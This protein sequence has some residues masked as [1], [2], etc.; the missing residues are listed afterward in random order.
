[1]R[2]DLTSITNAKLLIDNR[3]VEGR[4]IEI[5]RLGK[6][7]FELREGNLTSAMEIGKKVN[8]VF[9]ISGK[10]HFIAGKMFFQPPQK[11]IITPETDVQEEKRGN[12]RMSAPSLPATVTSQHRFFHHDEIKVLITDMSMKGA[13]IESTKPMKEQVLYNLATHFPYHHQQLPFS[14]SF[15]IKNCRSIH[16]VISYG[17]LFFDMDIESEQNLKKYLFGDNMKMN[18]R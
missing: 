5:D 16:N 6:I 4:I 18:F 13:R 1:M 17:I 12:P 9:D 10:S 14:S 11:I 15:H 3:T 7:F 8:I 2:I